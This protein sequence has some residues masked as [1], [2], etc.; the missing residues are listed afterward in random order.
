MSINL[1]ICIGIIIASLLLVSTS[2]QNA[3]DELSAIDERKV[4]VS[5]TGNGESRTLSEKQAEWFITDISGAGVRSKISKYP[6]FPIARIEHDGKEYLMHGNAVIHVQ[7][8][9]LE[10]LWSGPYLQTLVSFDGSIT[11]AIDHVETLSTLDGVLMD[12]PGAYP[13]G[14]P[15]PLVDD[16]QQ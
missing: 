9:G 7:D 13:G 12:A 2:C 10:F 1:K 14:G 4:I 11:D 15:A 16:D 8:D 5:D 6:A 3:V